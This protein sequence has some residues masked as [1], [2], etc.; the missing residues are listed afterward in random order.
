MVQILEKNT[1]YTTAKMPSKLFDRIFFI[2]TNDKNTKEES[3][4]GS[5]IEKVNKAKKEVTLGK[6]V[7]WSDFKKQYAW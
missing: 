7:T 1:K 4:S 5:E 6:I 3:L 2:S